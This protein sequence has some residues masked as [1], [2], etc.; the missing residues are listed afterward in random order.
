MAVAGAVI[1]ADVSKYY[2]G[3]YHMLVYPKCSLEGAQ[4]DARCGSNSIEKGCF[5][6]IVF[7]TKYTVFT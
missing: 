5:V 3:Q 2:R 6:L 7:Y 1:A 4:N